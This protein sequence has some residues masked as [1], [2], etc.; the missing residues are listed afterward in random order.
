MVVFGLDSAAEVNLR[1]QVEAVGAS[2]THVE[3]RER[4]D[5]T[6]PRLAIEEAWVDFEI[7]SDPFVVPTARGYAPAVLVRRDNAAHSEY[8][9]IGA[10]SLAQEL[11]RLRTKLGTLR[12]CRVSVR[13]QGADKIAPYSLYLR[14]TNAGGA[15]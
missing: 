10:K 7:Q 12:G 6:A 8:V 4:V 1:H 15:R 13:K 9:L 11:E 14:G 5:T 2:T 3:R